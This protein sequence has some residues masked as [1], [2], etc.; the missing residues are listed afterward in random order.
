MTQDDLCGCRSESSE[1]LFVSCPFSM[2]VM[3]L[4]K[5]SSGVLKKEPRWDLS[6]R[7][8]CCAAKGSQKRQSKLEVCMLPWSIAIGKPGIGESSSMSHLPLEELPLQ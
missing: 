7:W 5:N 2:E 6:L 3:E 4:L 8:L 1:H